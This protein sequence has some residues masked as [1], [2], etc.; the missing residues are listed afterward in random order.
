LSHIPNDLIIH[1]TILDPAMGGGQFVKEIERRKRAAGKTDEEIHKTVF[2]IEA[3]ILRRNYAV[4]KHKLVGDYQVGN[5]LTMDFN[6]MKFD[7]VI[8]NPPYKNGNNSSFYKKF[9]NLSMKIAP[10]VAMIVPSSN[11][12]KVQSFKNISYYS[13]QGTVFPGIQLVISWFIWQKNYN[14]LCYMHKSN[15]SV[16]F[17]DITVTPTNDSIIYNLVNKISKNA[18]G[19]DINGGKLL[20]KHAMVDS[21]GIWCIWSGGKANKDFDKCKVNISQKYLLNGFEQ[22]KVVFSEISTVTTI[23]PIKYAGPEYGC[24]NSSRFIVVKNEKEANNIIQYLNS[25]LIKA[26]IPTIKGTSAHNTK[27]VFKY[28]PSID[29]SKEW[30]DAKLYQYFNLTPEEID[31]IEK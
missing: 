27:S 10:I 17:N 25:K 11:F 5:A 20:R 18:N 28:I 24:A 8:G 16:H 12:S 23:G 19:F 14:S 6:G 22:H 4:N 13:Y 15:T 1:G 7:V 3:N 30:S 29:L 2:G 31:H 21:N 9:I 26:I